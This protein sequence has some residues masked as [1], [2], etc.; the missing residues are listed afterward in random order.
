MNQ[1]AE[2]KPT[3]RPY[4]N[5]KAGLIFKDTKTFNYFILLLMSKPTP[6]VFFCTKKGLAYLLPFFFL[7]LPLFPD[8]VFAV[9]P[10]NLI[11]L[12][13]GIIDIINL[14]RTFLI[15]LSVAI[16]IWGVF[17]Y[18]IVSG[19]EKRL[20]EAKDVI[21]YGLLGI[22]VMYLILGLVNIL[23]LTFTLNNA[24]PVIPQFTP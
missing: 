1:L 6:P 8:V 13:K 11:D 23:I 20:S 15:A 4:F 17:R 12:V 18:L 24:Q 5:S 14:L 22:L 21:V 7:G 2:P 3:S 9:A 16:I 19:D 10:Q